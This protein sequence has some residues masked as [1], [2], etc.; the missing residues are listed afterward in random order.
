MESALMPGG[1]LCGVHEQEHER[2]AGEQGAREA[3]HPVGDGRQVVVRVRVLG[4]DGHGGLRAGRR[5]ARTEQ[6]GDERE[7]HASG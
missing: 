3:R 7:R 2:V 6:H 1:Q 5:A 4:R